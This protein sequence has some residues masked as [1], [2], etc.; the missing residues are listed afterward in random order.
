MAINIYKDYV[1]FLSGAY[2]VT[3]HIEFP[4]S[5][6][7]RFDRQMHIVKRFHEGNCQVEEIANELWLSARTVREDLKQL[8]DGICSIIA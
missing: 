4:Q 1:D 8:E 7:S 5:F 3:I 2:G 6:N